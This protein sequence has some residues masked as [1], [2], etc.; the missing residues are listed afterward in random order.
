M[1]HFAR[2]DPARVGNYWRV[3]REHLT[4]TGAALVF[5]THTPEW[6]VGEAQHALC[7]RAGRA[8]YAGPVATLYAEPPDEE[9]MGYLGPGNWFTP[10]EARRWLRCNSPHRPRL[11]ASRATRRR[12]RGCR[13]AAVSKPSRFRGSCAELELRHVPSTRPAPFPPAGTRRISDRQIVQ[14]TALLSIV[15]LFFLAGCQRHVSTAE[16]TPREWRPAV[17]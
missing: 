3:I 2:V 11:P 17:A 6:A 9:L 4:K 16:L 7:L 5:S 13:R 10:T 12:T 8:L 15:L 14:L 1:S